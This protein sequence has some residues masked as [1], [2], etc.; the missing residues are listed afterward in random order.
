MGIL[1]KVMW[2]EM[3]RTSENDETINDLQAM[4][5]VGMFDDDDTDF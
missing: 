3:F 4:T 2:L 1:E 5:M